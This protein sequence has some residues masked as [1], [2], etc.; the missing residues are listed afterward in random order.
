MLT[1]GAATMAATAKGSSVIARDRPPGP[2]RTPGTDHR[3]AFRKYRPGAS[4]GLSQ[5]RSHQDCFRSSSVAG[6]PSSRARRVGPAARGRARSPT[7]RLE[8]GLGPA[9]D[10]R[11]A[12]GVGVV[13]AV[14]AF[15]TCRGANPP[16]RSGRD[17][18]GAYAGAHRPPTACGRG[19]AAHRC[20]HPGRRP[21]RPALPRL[22]IR[23]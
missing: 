22:L 19:R 8:G 12:S 1:S 14:P 9:L 16:D 4:S 11:A 15:A 18:R 13:R 23:W 21:L 10:R 7:C 2:R 3:L 20:A 6:T 17:Q 5:L